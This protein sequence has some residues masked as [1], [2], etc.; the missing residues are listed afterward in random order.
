[1]KKILI[2]HASAGAGHRKAAEA[3]YKAFQSLSPKDCH[4]ELVNILDF[5]S[6]FFKAGYEQSYLWT[7]KQATWLW[8][9]G[10]YWLDQKW[11]RMPVRILRR[12]VNRI[13]TLAFCQYLE[14][15]Q[16]HVILSTHF[17]ASEVVNSLKRGTDFRI[18]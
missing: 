12:I 16:Y 7:I 5:T 4:V 10:Y 17:L 9:F 11:M 6:P 1:M 18:S 15:E 14:K 13:N 8:G 2:V 3:V